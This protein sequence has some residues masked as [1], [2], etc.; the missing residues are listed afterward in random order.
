MGVKHRSSLVICP[1]LPV[2]CLQLELPAAPLEAFI[3]ANSHLP[4]T[5][6]CGTFPA[7]SQMFLTPYT[8]QFTLV[9][10]GEGERSFASIRFDG[11]RSGG[12]DLA[13]RLVT[14]HTCRLCSSWTVLK[15]A[16][17]ISRR[18]N[19]SVSNWTSGPTG[20]SWT[21]GR[22]HVSVTGL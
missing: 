19:S 7:L 11:L 14:S 17:F 16:F 13:H 3:N 8:G 6:G 5:L 9:K 22:W 20:T 10:G 2:S 4:Q 18:R 1:S 12:G 21:R 15:D